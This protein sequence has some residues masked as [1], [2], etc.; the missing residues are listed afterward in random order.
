METG[1][2]SAPQ[3]KKRWLPKWLKVVLIVL[4]VIFGLPAL[5]QVAHVVATA[6]MVEIAD[7]MRP[8]PEWR[9]DGENITG[10]PFCVSYAVDCDSMW[11]SYR[12]EH[13]VVPADL[14]RISDEAMGDV[15]VK[16]DCVT[17]PLPPNSDGMFESCS[18][19]AVIDGYDVKARVMNLSKNS[20]ARI[21]QFQISSIK[22]RR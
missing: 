15:K 14:Q 2:G 7:R 4:A 16:G 8:N 13:Q 22:N 17:S 10:G 12:T 20:S 6:P 1:S 11:R 18:V 19:A 3:P 5:M 21:I 9:Q